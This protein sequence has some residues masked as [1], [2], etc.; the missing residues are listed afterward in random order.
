MGTPRAA[1]GDPRSSP[2]GRAGSHRSPSPAV[3]GSLWLCSLSPGHLWGGAGAR[4]RGTPP[5]LFPCHAGTSAKPGDR[6]CPPPGAQQWGCMQAGMRG[7]TWG[8]VSSNK[9]SLHGAGA[10]GEQTQSR[11]EMNGLKGEESAGQ[12]QGSAWERGEEKAAAHGRVCG[13]TA[14]G[15]GTR[16]APSRWDAGV[17]MAAAQARAGSREQCPSVHSHGAK[18]R[19]WGDPGTAAR[20]HCSTAGK[21]HQRDT[22]G[23]RLPLARPPTESH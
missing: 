19:G 22:S 23:S 20:H 8:W 18:I 12:S 15:T 21:R 13:G 14:V 11:S 7:P 5:L 16:R 10:G 3:R 2:W 17:P 9:R 4:G 6:R 1:H